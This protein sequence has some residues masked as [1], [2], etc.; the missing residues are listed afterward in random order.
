MGLNRL[1]DTGAP[2]SADDL[3]TLRRRFIEGAERRSEWP[4]LESINPSDPGKAVQALGQAGQAYIRTLKSLLEETQ[5]Y[6]PDE[7]ASR[8]AER[9]A[10]TDILWSR[11]VHRVH[12]MVFGV[13]TTP[14]RRKSPP[15]RP[16]ESEGWPQNDPRFY[17][18]LSRL[19]RLQLDSRADVEAHEQ[20][21]LPKDRY[22]TILTGI[23]AKSG[24]QLG[25]LAELTDRH[26]PN[27]LSP[28]GSAQVLRVARVFVRAVLLFGRRPPAAKWM[29]AP[30]P[31]P[32]RETEQTPLALWAGSEE[33]AR[34]A[35]DEL[36]RARW[37]VL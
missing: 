11:D 7:L 5:G 16:S 32:D 10:F 6:L 3:A 27:R 31:W 4:D 23:D 24:P 22:Y 14:R 19:V 15:H 30:Q 37:G 26:D 13:S 21:G 36:A 25:V 33:G 12:S 1:S 34:Q 20:A 2:H 29:L 9:C 8:I 35:E 18:Y 28:A 17:R